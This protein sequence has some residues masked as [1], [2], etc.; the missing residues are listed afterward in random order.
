MNFRLKMVAWSVLSIALIV[1]GLLGAAHWHL[2]GELRK[3]GRDRSHGRNPEWVIH[4]S[5]TDAEVQDILGELMTVWLWIAVPLVLASGGVGYFI[6]ERSLRPVSRINR[7]LDSLDPL[8]CA[9]GV[10][11]PERDA[12]LAAL[13]HHINDLLGRVGKSYSEMA[14][15]SS[16]VAHELRLP[17][18]LLRLRLEAL[19]PELPP[20]VSEDLQE[21]IGHLSQLVERSL[22]MSKAEGGTLEH[23]I[24]PVDL[25]AL[26]EDLHDGYSILAAEA[27]LTLLWQPDPGLTVNSDP[28]LL[29]QILHNLL[30]NAIRHGKGGI[31]LAA[32]RVEDDRR[33]LLEI[34]NGI[35]EGDT[36]LLGTGM[37]LRLV[38]AIAGT[39]AGTAFRTEEKEGDFEASLE[40][41]GTDP[42]TLMGVGGYRSAELQR[43]P[44]LLR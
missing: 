9:Q 27:G 21:E 36:S 35:A 42:E 26:L 43:R 31:R 3:D 17:L 30:G 1:T 20:E 15:F 10:Q 40:L 38:R 12:E 41:P 5:Y 13:V 7:E 34:R 18:T 14:E 37:G 32:R 19:A 39:L 24:Q 2:D 6:A 4:G 11:L 33:V 44:R 8:S 28:A 29:R 22:L 25:S 23:E 16:R